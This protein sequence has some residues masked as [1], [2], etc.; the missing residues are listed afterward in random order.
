MI[1][2]F[3]RFAKL[4]KRV[5]LKVTHYLV[6][7]YRLFQT[8]SIGLLPANIAFFTIWSLIPIIIL[9]DSVVKL[10]PHISS[11]KI[12][13]L[14]QFTSVF[15]NTTIDFTFGFENIA[16]VV[17]IVYLASRPFISII[18][19]SNYIYG[20]DHSSSFLKELFKGILCAL[21]ILITY[22]L[23]LIIT[24]LG[25]ELVAIFNENIKADGIIKQ[26]E[27][28]K[29]PFTIIYLFVIVFTIYT[30]AP[31]KR[32]K[33][34]YFIPGTIFCVTGWMLSTKLYSIYV[35][36]FADYEKIYSSY[37]TIIIMMIWIYILSFILIL[38][39]VINASYYGENHAHE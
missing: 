20:L 23:L 34:K 32:I 2:V 39:L 5:Q 13:D 26:F 4:C 15:N 25:D 33:L 11:E 31:N 12:I 6:C 18:R 10:I 1:K 35:I 22:V 9:W 14:S 19:S 8:N 29:I 17:I 36:D 27:D 21:L 30:M 7:A 3:K 37:T 38:G 24:V 28:V 16:F